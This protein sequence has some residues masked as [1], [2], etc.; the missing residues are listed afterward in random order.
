MKQNRDPLH[1]IYISEC[2][3]RIEQYVSKGKESFLSSP[4][5][6]DAVLRNLQTLAESTQLLSSK[7]KFTHRDIP[8]RH[9]A[10]L[11]NLIVHDYLGLDMVYVWEMIVKDLPVLKKK[12][13]M[14]L[15]D[16]EI[17]S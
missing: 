6:Q 16:A 10:G 17:E 2:I 8:W 7:I 15:L 9:Y 14:I 13:K 4:L 5:L 1:L 11:R 12:I 3:D